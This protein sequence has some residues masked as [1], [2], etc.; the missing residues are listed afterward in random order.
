MNTL[1]ERIIQISKKYHLSHL[2]SSLTSVNIIDEIYKIK[3]PD[4]VFINSCGHAGL[5][6][7]VVIEKY[8]GINAEDI[9]LHHGSTHPDRCEKCHI[10]CST[11]SLGMGLPIAVGMALT[12]REKNV[13]C[14]IS[15]GEAFEGSIWEAANVIQKYNITNLKIYINW[16]GFSAYDIVPDWMLTN[17]CTIFPEINIRHTNVEDYGLNGI[18]AHYKTL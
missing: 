11:G 7:F 10:Y 1:H 9:Y 6:L 3:K 5:A 12:D 14:L 15:D 13:Y 17:I 16:N 2:G 18:S 4:E 8:E